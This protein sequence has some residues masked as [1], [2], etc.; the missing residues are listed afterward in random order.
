[1]KR[2]LMILLALAICAA[3]FA[4][5]AELERRD[6][7]LKGDNIARGMIAMPEGGLL[8]Y[9][10]TTVAGDGS[11]ASAD[12]EDAYQTAWAMRL[13][14]NHDI[15]WHSTNIGSDVQTAFISAAV[16]PN[17]EV[18]LLGNSSNE[19]RLS[20]IYFMNANDGTPVR[21]KSSETAR[22]QQLCVNGEYLIAGGTTQNSA[23][24]KP[25]LYISYIDD[26]DN[27]T[28]HWSDEETFPTEISGLYS[29]DQLTYVF[30]TARYGEHPYTQAILYLLTD[31]GS[32]TLATQRRFSLEKA[33]LAAGALYA[34]NTAVGG[35]IQLPPE[36]MLDD[37]LTC[38][39]YFDPLSAETLWQGTLNENL[40][41]SV[42]AIPVRDEERF[43]LAGYQGSA[44]DAAIYP[45]DIALAKSYSK[46]PG[47]SKSIKIS[48]HSGG[49]RYVD[50]ITDG[51][52]ILLIGIK[53][54]GD[55]NGVDTFLFTWEYLAE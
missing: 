31:K 16:M 22:Y 23:D 43:V 51:D 10:S 34:S 32:S 33:D 17:G 48:H 50:A 29:V 55:E 41:T 49:M 18:A 11:F 15:M 42:T 30:F 44:G 3:C 25:F 7:I 9:G 36:Q 26:D 14:P 52:A 12:E 47:P 40:F 5:L 1:M 27:K 53:D 37:G 46:N 13:A 45:G 4:G 28:H 20:S 35:V 54:F 6:Y 8:V 24:E 38:V 21:R 39:M 2:M 19:E